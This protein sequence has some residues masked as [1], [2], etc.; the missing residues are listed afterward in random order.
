M[1]QILTF[2][3]RLIPFVLLSLSS[4]RPKASGASASPAFTSNDLFIRIVPELAFLACKR[5][6]KYIWC[7]NPLMKSLFQIH[8][9]LRVQV[10]RSSSKLKSL[11]KNKSNMTRFVC[12]VTN[13]SNNGSNITTCT[14]KFTYLDIHIKHSET[15]WILYHC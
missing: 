11:K 8:S 14:I 10:C 15:L 7:L 9:N 13:L 1:F 2:K 5:K 12:S 6:K 4:T 3:L